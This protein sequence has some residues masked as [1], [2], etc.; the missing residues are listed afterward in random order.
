MVLIE[1]RPFNGVFILNMVEYW[2]RTK[3]GI[4][5]EWHVLMA[6]ACA[7]THRYYLPLLIASCNIFIPHLNAQACRPRYC[8]VRLEALLR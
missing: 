6:I 4:D 2:Q 5:R 3:A 7:R 1:K 8:H